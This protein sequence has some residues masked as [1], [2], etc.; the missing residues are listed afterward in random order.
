MAKKAPPLQKFSSGD[1]A[2]LDMAITGKQLSKGQLEPAKREPMLKLGLIEIRKKPKGRGDEIF[3]TEVGWRHLNE[4]KMLDF[5][6]KP[7]VSAKVLQ[8]LLPCV[9]R[10]LSFHDSSF[11]SLFLSQPQDSSGKSEASYQENV[12]GLIRAAYLELTSGRFDI[13]VRMKHLREKLRDADA[14]T[15]SLCLMG[16]ILAGRAQAA[17]IADALVIDDDDCAAALDLGGHPKQ[18]IRILQ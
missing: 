3:L 4:N 7:N 9:H 18:L 11:S 14:E 5:G 6:K 10:F 1:L 13:D 16:M 8:S 12:P 15:V 17:H 2:L